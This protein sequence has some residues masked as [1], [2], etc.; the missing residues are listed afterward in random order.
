MNHAFTARQ[1]FAF[2]AQGD[3]GYIHGGYNCD[4]GLLKDMYMAKFNDPEDRQWHQIV[5]KGKIPGKL[6]YHT[7]TSYLCYILCVGGQ[8]SQVQNNKEIFYFNLQNQMW[9]K[10][11]IVPE[12]PAL[13]EKDVKESLGRDSHCSVVYGKNL[14]IFGGYSFSQGLYSN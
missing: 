5:Q 7:L 9:S 4:E 13:N 2:C 11:E 3:I 1:A 10:L 6:R 14:Y 12:D 8:R